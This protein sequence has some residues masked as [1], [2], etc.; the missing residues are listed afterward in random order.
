M[1]QADFQSFSSIQLLALAV[2]Y[3][4]YRTMIDIELDRRSK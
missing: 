2:K 1:S 4:Q 3:P